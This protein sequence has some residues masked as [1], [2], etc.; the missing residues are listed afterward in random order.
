[1]KSDLDLW[2]M[3]RVQYSE[4]ACMYRLVGCYFDCRPNQPEMQPFQGWIPSQP[5]PRVG[6]QGQ[7]NPGLSHFVPLGQPRMICRHSNAI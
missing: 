4:F 6:P 7:A 3:I 2:F 1:M 5:F